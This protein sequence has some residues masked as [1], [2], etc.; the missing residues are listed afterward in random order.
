MKTNEIA[1]S[2]HIVRNKIWV[3]PTGECNFTQ[4]A[5]SLIVYSCSLHFGDIWACKWAGHVSHMNLVVWPRSPRVS[6]SSVVRASNRHLEG[7]G[8]DSRWE[9]WEFFLRAQFHLFRLLYWLLLIEPNSG[10]QGGQVLLS[11]Q[12][13]ATKVA[14]VKFLELM[15]YMGWVCCWFSFFPRF[16]S[17]HKSNIL[18]FQFHLETVSLLILIVY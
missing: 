7:H 13:P 15:P 1:L 5:I 6:H 12:S 10:E 14:W 3:L 4:V 17:C 16:S 18:N 8:F 9:D 11:E 2:S